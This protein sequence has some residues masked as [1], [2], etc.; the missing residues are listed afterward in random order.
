MQVPI[1]P[2]LLYE[3]GEQSQ[4][5]RLLQLVGAMYAPTVT[6]TVLSP[7]DPYYAWDS[8]VAACFLEPSI[9][10]L[11][12]ETVSIVLDGK[13]QGRMVL[14]QASGSNSSSSSG[15]QAPGSTSSSSSSGS[16]GSGSQPAAALSRPKQVVAAVDADAGKFDAFLLKTFS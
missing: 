14:S 15:S 11:Q 13:S 1:T 3:F 6:W 5:S 12:Q 8:L 10:K 4:D 2:A 7:H 16:G 9:C